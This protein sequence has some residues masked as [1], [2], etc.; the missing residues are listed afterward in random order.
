MEK[1]AIHG[2][3]QAIAKIYQTFVH[4]QI[5]GEFFKKMNDEYFRVQIASFES[6]IIAKLQQLAKDY[7]GLKHVLPTNSGTS[8]LFEMFYASGLQRGDEVIVPA[9]TYFATV[10]PLFVLGCTPVLVDC[11]DNGSID[12]DEI[13]KKITSKTK[14]IVITHMWGIPCDMDEIMELSRRYEIPVL[15][16]ASH[17]HGAH[18]QGKMIGTFGKCA[19][20]S[21]GS[22]KLISGGQGGLLGT[23]DDE[24]FQKAVLLGGSN[25]K[26]R[27]EVNLK[28]LLP[29]NVSGVG[30]NL[31]MHPYAAALLIDQFEHY[32]QQVHERNE[33]AEFF[34]KEIEKIPGLSIPRTPDESKL[35][36]YVFPILYNP[37][38]F[39][40]VSRDK[41]VEAL[42]AEGAGDVEIPTNMPPLTDFTIF[43]E[44]GVHF[45]RP[46]KIKHYYQ[47]GEFKNAEK[48]HA[49]MIRL[50]VWYGEKRFEYARAHVAAI[51]KVIEHIGEFRA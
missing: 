7:F 30:L 1:L 4:P 45:D 20:W 29:Y 16:D 36:W 31:R 42:Y 44:R 9:Y 39:N 46:E 11:R 28:H 41:F 10:N 26:R 27:P 22:R 38:Y 3:D 12:P 51:K 40:N 37:Q 23:N 5:S 32:R 49:S 48:F 24:V 21:M 43:N 8:A 19:A 6:P 35:V 14:A 18:Y 17:A 13:R 34:L 33:T 47:T 15:E 2:G 25:I 50:P